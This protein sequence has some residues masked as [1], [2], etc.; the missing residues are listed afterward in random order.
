MR[1]ALCL[2]TLLSAFGFWACG[3]NDSVA[4]TATQTENTVASLDSLKG[5]VYHM[6]GTRAKG[7]LVRMVLPNKLEKGESPNLRETETDSQ[8][9]FLFVDVP[10]DTFQLAVIDTAFGEIL[11]LPQASAEDDSLVLEQA[12]VI[13]GYLTYDDS[14]LMSISVGSHFKVYVSDLPLY[15]TVF[16]PSKFELLVPD[17]SW[18]LGFCPGDPLVIEK[19]QES[20]IPDSVIFRS[21]E[22]PKSLKPGETL[23]TDTLVW[24]VSAKSAVS[25]STGRGSS[26]KG[27]TTGTPATSKAWISGQVDCSNLTACD[28]V[29]VMVITDLFGFDFT[30]G[31]ILEYQVQALTD[32]LGRWWLPAPEVVPYDSFRVEYR[33][34]SGE[35]VSKTGLSRYVKK[36]ELKGGNDTL[37]IG[38]TSL[39]KYSWIS[40]GVRLVVD[41]EDNQQTENC[42]MNSVVLGIEGT[43]HFVR[44]VTCD[45]YYL[46]YL[47]SGTQRLLMY[48]GDPVVV[49][50]LQ[51]AGVPQAAY[52]SSSDQNLTPGN[53]I[54]ELWLTYTPPNMPLSTK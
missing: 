39:D 20:G 5:A 53:G 3:N 40:V 43:S 38:K 48:S 44:T 28:S 25:D 42:L 23:V 19:L 6:D 13:K 9:R 51:E 1:L 18:T 34:R 2:A 35:T 24:N 32:S 46:T 29:E 31:L 27:D 17:G 22:T 4:G 37:S 15:E 47:P 54:K 26:E 49:S 45:K 8:G 41:Q 33:Q 21:W 50:A 36:S 30:A 12:A 10:A 7:A 52:V 14:V 16:A 11:Y